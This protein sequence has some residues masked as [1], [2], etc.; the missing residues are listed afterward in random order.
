MASRE[1]LLNL[2]AGSSNTLEDK[3]DDSPWFEKG[4]STFMSETHLV[5]VVANSGSTARDHLANERTYLAWLRTAIS[6]VALGLGVV[7][8]QPDSLVALAFGSYFVLLGTFTLTFS[9]VRYYDVMHSLQLGKFSTNTGA[10]MVFQAAMCLFP[11][12]ALLA[13]FYQVYRLRAEM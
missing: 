8:L 10:V 6:L 9:M 4:A 12:G 2:E 5:Q 7:K 11:V 3:P 13:I 1:P